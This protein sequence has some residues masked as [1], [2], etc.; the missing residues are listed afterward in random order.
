MAAAKSASDR[1]RARTSWFAFRASYSACLSF[2]SATASS[3]S[4]SSFWASIVLVACSRYFTWAWAALMLDSAFFS[5]DCASVMLLLWPVA[6]AAFSAASCASRRALAASSLRFGHL[7]LP[8]RIIEG[9]VGAG[10]RILGHAPLHL[11]A[12]RTSPNWPSG[13]RA[14]H[15][16]STFAERVE[17]QPTPIT[18]RTAPIITPAKT[19]RLLD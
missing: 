8:A 12:S 13:T 9:H 4:L 16:S 11:R 7:Q 19:R 14:S 2:A 17:L 10:H 5:S 3:L 1:F 15:D 6:L 18:D